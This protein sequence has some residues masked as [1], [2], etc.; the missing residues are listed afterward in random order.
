MTKTGKVYLIG[1]GPGDAGLLTVKA[2]NLLE[3]AQ[4]V[5]YDRLVGKE[6]LELIPSGAQLI[7][8]GKYA[9][10]HPVPQHEINQILLQK[11]R[12]GVD[13]IRLK[14]GDSFVFG[15]GGEEL[16]LLFQN[17]IEFEVVP[18]VTSAIAAATYAGIPVTHRD[19]CSSVHLITGHKKKD[20]ALDLDYASLAALDGTLIFMMSVANVGEISQGLLAAGM[21]AQMPCAV[22]ENGT[23]PA[24]RKFLATLER[25]TDAVREN[26]IQSPALIIV[27]RVCSLSDQFDW[28]SMLPLKGKRIL[29][30]RPK[31]TSHRLS[32]KL[33]E[34]GACVQAFAAIR[35][36]PLAFVL[37]NLQ[38]YSMLVFT[39]AAGVHAYFDRL[40]EHSDAR[41]IAGKRIAV[42]GRETGNALLPYGLKPDFIPSVFSGETLGMELLEHLTAEDKLLLLRAQKSAPELT[43]ILSENNICFDEISVYETRYEKISGISAADFDLLTF[44]SASCVEGFMEAVSN[45]QSFCRIPAVCIGEKTAQA[46]RRHGFEPVIAKEATIDSMVER[47]L[48][49]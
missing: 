13:V 15:R 11:A 35:T 47:I 2:K 9:G 22:V 42:I 7:D 36:T 25:I 16:E 24:Q 39:S 37:P 14:G 23:L 34:L 6:I 5:V 38:P 10:N 20:G 48:E 46:A 31:E 18:G 21:D 3:Q 4:V 40:F 28:F 1:A 44:T 33:R 29:V 19:F 43:N 32:S 27:G 30:T 45:P 12:E 17:N 26:A 41:A 8:V 49:L